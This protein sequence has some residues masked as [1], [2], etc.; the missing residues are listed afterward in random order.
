MNKCFVVI[1][2]YGDRHS[3]AVRKL[4][5]RLAA[6]HSTHCEIVRTD[7]PEAAAFVANPNEA[8]EFSGYQEG[9][10]KIS[11]AAKAAG[12]GD[13]D[14]ATFVFLNDTAISSHIK[15][16]SHLSLNI[17]FDNLKSNYGQ[18]NEY[19]GLRMPISSGIEQVSGKDGYLSTWLFALRASLRTLSKVRF[20]EEPENFEN[21]SKSVLPGLPARYLADVD[22]WLRPTHWLKGWY[23]AIPGRELDRDTRNRKLM[24]IYLEHRLPARLR[25]LDFIVAD[26]SVSAS[27]AQKARLSKLRVA[28]RLNTNF[29]KLRL[30]A[31]HF[32]KKILLKP[33]NR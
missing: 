8:M 26:I 12:L 18:S 7:Q 22:S 3:F 24:S 5:R 28:D 1:V 15:W 17:L 9:L 21:F 13:D 30:R 11:A 10:G 19:I 16:L 31:P 25:Q 33:F 2:Q 32:L 4:A 6:Q 29:I 14:T 23:Q 20:Y 27:E